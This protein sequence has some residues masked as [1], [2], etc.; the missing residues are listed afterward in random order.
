MQPFTESQLSAVQTLPSS[1]A[2][3]QSGWQAPPPQVSP[4]VHTATV[5]GQVIGRIHATIHRM[6][7]VRGG[8]LVVVAIERDGAGDA[9]GARAHIP[10]GAGI[11]I[12]V[13]RLVGRKHTP[14]SVVQVS[15]VH[16]FPSLPGSSAAH[17]DATGVSLCC[18]R[19][20]HRTG[21]LK[22]TRSPP[23][24]CSF[25][26]CRHF[27][28]HNRG[29]P[30]NAY[31]LGAGVVCGAFISVVARERVGGL[32]QPVVGTQLSVV[33]TFPSS[34]PSAEVSVPAQSPR[35]N[36]RRRYT[37]C[38]HRRPY[39]GSTRNLYLRC[40][41]RRCTHCHHAVGYLTSADSLGAGVA[42]GAGVSIIACSGIVF[43]GA[44]STGSHASVVQ[45]LLSLHRVVSP[46][47][48]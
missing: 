44:S 27:H 39:W 31:G 43:E 14:S 1:Q 41:H 35:R 8:T 32:T 18:R 29:C 19:F 24:H 16:T 12:G 30:A 25:R 36:H 38:R 4:R 21:A 6:A 22:C 26:R 11:A 40:M 15:S 23:P 10:C 33:H 34:P 42:R 47:L 37:H 2:R 46:A 5:T 20:R 45:G 48:H 28:H 7:A 3:P 9:L 17:A 13:V